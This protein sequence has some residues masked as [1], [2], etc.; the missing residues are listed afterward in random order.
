MNI[1]EHQIPNYDDAVYI[2]SWS[3][4]NLSLI[5]Y[6]ISILPGNKIDISNFK[7]KATD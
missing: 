4:I 5:I 7:E 2:D 6:K 1:P 3:E